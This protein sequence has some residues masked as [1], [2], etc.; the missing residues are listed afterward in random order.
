LL[1]EHK[2]NEARSDSTQK[3]LIGKPQSDNDN[4]L[5]DL[6]DAIDRVVNLFDKEDTGVDDIL[7]ATE[8]AE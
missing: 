4:L 7:I 5:E 8:K 1:D 6:D 3:V 2:Y